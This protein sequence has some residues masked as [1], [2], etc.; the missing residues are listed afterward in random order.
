MFFGGITDMK[1]LKLNLIFI[2]LFSV[3]IIGCFD[4]DN[5]P[6]TKKPVVVIKDLET[7]VYSS[8]TIVAVIT[9]NKGVE[10][11]TLYYTDPNGA[12]S[13]VAMN[14]SAGNDWQA[15]WNPTLGLEGTYTFTVEAQ[16]RAGNK[17]T[18]QKSTNYQT[19][20]FSVSF[21]SPLNDA[22]AYG[23]IDIEL[24]AQGNLQPSS[25]E[26]FANDNSV[27]TISSSPWIFTWDSSAEEFASA[28]LLTAEATYAGDLEFETSIQLTIGA[29]PVAL[30]ELFTSY[31]CDNCP[32]A[33]EE[34]HHLYQEYA[35]QLSVIE[36]H[37]E[38]IYSIQDGETRKLYYQVLGWPTAVFG[39][40]ESILGGY[41]ETVAQYEE[42]V[43]NILDNPSKFDM[44]VSGDFASGVFDIQIAATTT[45]LPDDLVLRTVLLENDLYQE[46]KH[47]NFVARDMS[48][49]IALE[50]F[51]SVGETRT[52]QISYNILMG[53]VVENFEFVAFIQS[54]DTKEV[55][56]TSF[57]INE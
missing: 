15:T 27:G 56:Q 30:A 24:S 25:I 16:D 5:L 2:L 1:L 17:A 13:S 29:K 50:S 21:D 42:K 38:D 3:L 36:Y 31:D 11:A 46:E 48:D 19:P 52:Y 43:L 26:I 7:T 54:D 45:D 12:L 6:E 33:E 23:E 49:D 10:S 20:E 57:I 28:V 37:M 34:I 32:N 18:N 41:E 51:T 22:Y 14:L 39:G 8:L 55:L 40:T 35:G 44:S 53:W 4:E 9:D 47:F